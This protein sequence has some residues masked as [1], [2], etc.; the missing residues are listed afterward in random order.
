MSNF[1]SVES[2][3]GITNFVITAKSKSFTEAAEKLG[4]TKSAVGKSIARLE[5]RLGTRL[6][7]RSTRKLSL[8]SDGEAYLASCLSALEILDAAENSL[9]RRQDKPSGEVR[10]D[11]PISFGRGLMMP[12]LIQI[13]KKYPDLRFTLTF[14]DRFIDPLEEGLD[15]VLRL[16]ELHDTD[17]LISR[18][19]SSQRLYLCATPEYIEKYGEPN[20]PEDLKNHHCIM[21]YRR[22]SPLA[23]KLRSP[24]TG[25]EIKY[26]AQNSHQVSDGDALLQSCIGGMGIVQLPETMVNS[27][28]ANGTLKLLLESYNPLPSELHILWPR[29]KHLIP[30][31]RMI[32]DELILKASEG[33]FGNLR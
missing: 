8:T 24:T 18:Y 6:F 9:S 16:G 23:W 14:N 4:I 28:L 11:M 25:N 19:L 21:G 15:L 12:L 20:S 5:D 29:T 1:V 27:Y 7:H 22:G 2:L 10:I 26:I 3:K 30:K 31:V 32:I 13:A 33:Y 17:E